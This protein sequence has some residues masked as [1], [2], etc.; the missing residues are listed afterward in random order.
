M[1]T[2]KSQEQLPLKPPLQLVILHPGHPCA[3]V[4]S[5]ESWNLLYGPAVRAWYICL[6]VKP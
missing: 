5:L 4:C 2:T 3:K 1:E 6:A